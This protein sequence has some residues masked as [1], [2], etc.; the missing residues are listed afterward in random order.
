MVAKEG[1]PTLTR[2]GEL[3]GTPAFMAPEQARG[4]VELVDHQSDLYSLGATLFTLLT[5]KLLNEADTVAEMLVLAM[6]R[7]SPSLRDAM[8]EMPDAL[9]RAID[10][11]LE[12]DKSKRWATAD[13]MRAAL[14]ESYLAL[15]GKC[16]P[17]RTPSSLE[18][19]ARPMVNG[20]VLRLIQ[21]TLRPLPKARWLV[22]LA[23]VVGVAGVVLASLVMPRGL[24]AATAA[25][26]APMLAETSAP[27]KA[28]AFPESSVTAH[29]YNPYDRRH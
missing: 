3:I 19:A 13:A 7:N 21:T 29:R 17:P 5:G 27:V 6:T 9:V 23:I 8:P 14:E 26:K 28:T 22:G 20:R 18:A 2:T 1:A 24:V 15:T 12:L 4:R 11:A 16:A 10:G 25:P